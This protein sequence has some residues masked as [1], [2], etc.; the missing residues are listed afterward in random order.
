MH[1]E[2]TGPVRLREELLTQGLVIIPTAEPHQPAGQGISLAYLEALAAVLM[3][4]QQSTQPETDTALLSTA[5]VWSELVLPALA[6]PSRKNRWAP[7]KGC[8]CGHPHLCRP[9]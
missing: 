9:I 6:Q 7:G 3:K 1:V 5:E 2:T 4:V 8:S